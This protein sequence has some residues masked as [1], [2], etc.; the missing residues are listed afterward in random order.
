[1]SV[2]DTIFVMLSRIRESVKNAQYIEEWIHCGTLL[3]AAAGR[4][5]IGWGERQWHSAPRNNS[6]GP[7]FYFPDFF[8]T[9]SKHWFTHQ[10]T[11][12]LSVQELI[13]ELN[14]INFLKTVLPRHALPAIQWHNPYQSHFRKTFEELKALFLANDLDKAVP[15]VFEVAPQRMDTDRLCSSLNSLLNYALC[16]P[17]HLYGFWGEGEGMLGATPEILFQFVDSSKLKTV[18]CA[19]T[20]GVQRDL[21]EFMCD[22][23]EQHEHQLV[24]QGIKEA[25]SPFGEVQL[26]TPYLLKLS[27]LVHLTTP[28]EVLLRSSSFSYEQI[29]HALH[30]TPAVGPFPKEKGRRWLAE[31]QRQLDR[32]RYG[33]PCGV[34]FPDLAKS[35]CYVSIRNVQWSH[36]QMRIGAG[37]GLVAE[38]ECEREWAEINLKLRAIKEMLAL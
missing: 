11:K 14:Q 33:A 1:M 15:Y 17:A 7:S 27:R 30:P 36:E 37:C 31:Q 12:E 2:K 10:H 18:A 29:V 38:S 16:N 21:S 20:M 26:H 9:G 23:K 35:T 19:G 5:L 24:V 8:L 22:P 6:A 13:S 25:L 3:G 28:I 32:V 34:L 4:V